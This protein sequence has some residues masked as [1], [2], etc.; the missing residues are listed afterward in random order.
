MLRSV[1][2]PLL[3]LAALAA[4]GADI[5]LTSPLAFGEADEVETAAPATIP[6]EAFMTG[7]VVEKAQLDGLELSLRQGEGRQMVMEVV[8]PGDAPVDLNLDLT[9]MVTE[10]SMMGRMMPMP[11]S[12]SQLDLVRVIEPGQQVEVP[13][14]YELPEAA[15]GPM[16]YRTVEVALATGDETTSLRY[17]TNSLLLAQ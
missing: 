15:L 13:V 16:E 12:V 5:A 7:P 17:E 3:V 6:V 2:T 11:R 1:P 8:N 4:V 14:G 9:A 10:G